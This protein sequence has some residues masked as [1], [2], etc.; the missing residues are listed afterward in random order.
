M[1]P[2]LCTAVIKRKISRYVVL[3]SMHLKLCS[4]IEE[5]M[6]QKKR[7]HVA[8]NGRAGTYPGAKLTARA[9]HS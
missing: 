1:S 5:E 4:A 2:K 7:Q 8:A 6:I 9:P 3:S